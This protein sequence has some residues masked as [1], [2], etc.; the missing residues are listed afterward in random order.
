MTPLHIEILL[1]Y[2]CRAEPFAIREPEHARSTV[3]R[4]FRASLMKDNLIYESSTSGSGYTLTDRGK[5][6]IEFIL[7]TPLPVCKWVRP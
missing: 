2:H 6:F 7:D 5:A 1:W 3:V 4:D